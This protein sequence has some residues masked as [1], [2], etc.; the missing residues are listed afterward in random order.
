MTEKVVSLS[1][2]LVLGMVCALFL[3]IGA[4][5]NLSPSVH[6]EIPAILQMTIAQTTHSRPAPANDTTPN[7]NTATPSNEDRGR[8]TRIATL[9]ETSDPVFTTT[10]T[11]TQTDPK[12]WTIAST[13]KIENT[14][15]RV[16]LQRSYVASNPQTTSTFISL[17]P[18]ARQSNYTTIIDN[19]TAEPTSRSEP[20]GIEGKPHTQGS[21]TAH[22]PNMSYP[23]DHDPA[24]ASKPSTK[25]RLTSDSFIDSNTE[26]LVD[27]ERSNRVATTQDHGG[28][29]ENDPGNPMLHQRNRR[30]PGTD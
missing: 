24:T 29:S 20:S 23:R 19:A 14:L 26:G 15:Q 28:H 1:G 12:N 3:G 9:T 22:N 25:P 13:P 4:T 8:I 21:S 6:F 27:S 2:G 30:R 11:T 10:A 16:N 7:I 17:G 18:V 5:Q